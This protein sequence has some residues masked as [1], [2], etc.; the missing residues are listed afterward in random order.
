MPDLR[1]GTAQRGAVGEAPQDRPER[2]WFGRAVEPCFVTPV[3]SSAGDGG[4]EEAPPQEPTKGRDVSSL[5]EPC[6]V[7]VAS[8]AL[9]N[10][11]IT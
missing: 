8:A 6:A 5:L 9:L 4:L 3:L 1:S 11:P 10:Y 2:G 7:K